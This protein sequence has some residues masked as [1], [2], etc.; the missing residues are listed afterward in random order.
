[1]PRVEYDAI[2]VEVGAWQFDDGKRIPYVKLA[3]GDSILTATLMEGVE[4]PVTLVKGAADVEFYANQSGKLKA[5]MHGFN[6]YQ[7]HVV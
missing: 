3:D 7:E 1:M 4:A 5:R 6:A 2:V